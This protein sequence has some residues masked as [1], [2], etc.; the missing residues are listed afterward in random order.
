MWFRVE[1]NK[2]GSVAKCD[3]VEANESSR[4]GRVYFIEADSKEHA[5][6]LGLKR[7]RAYLESQRQG[8]RERRARLKK[9]GLCRDCS[10]AL[11]PEAKSQRSIRCSACAKRAYNLRHKIEEPGKQGVVRPERLATR[12]PEDYRLAVLLEIRGR[13]DSLGAGKFYK[14][15]NREIARCEAASAP[16]ATAAE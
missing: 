6:E 5:L 4:G 10:G 16:R 2:D 8:M 11:D 14:W 9:A 1:L 3:A 7:Y 12:L 15:L 13:I